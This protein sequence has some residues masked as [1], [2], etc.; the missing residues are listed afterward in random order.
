MQVI[1]KALKAWH[2]EDHR[3]P[4]YEQNHRENDTICDRNGSSLFD[5]LGTSSLE[6][7][8][9]L[10][11]ARWLAAMLRALVWAQEAGTTSSETRHEVADSL[12]CMAA[13][14]VSRIIS[15]QAACRQS[16]L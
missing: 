11:G 12:P 8:P 2:H 9:N 3:L 5:A 4:P 15:A 13:T 14:H 10:P 16:M 6:V 7:G 1:C